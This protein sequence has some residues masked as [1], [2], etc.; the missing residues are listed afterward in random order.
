MKKLLLQLCIFPVLGFMLLTEPVFI[1]D[2]K[3]VFGQWKGSLTYLDYSSG[4]PYSMPANVTISKDKKNDHR[5]ILA[6]QYPDEPKANENDTLVIS[7][8]G[9]Q[10]DGAK[11]V[12]KEKTSIGLLQI[13]TEKQGVD[14]NDNRKA[15][16]KHI[17]TISKK[18][19]SIRK[20][21]RFDGEEKFI[22]RNEYKMNR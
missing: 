15:V 3:P 9:L 18:V 6:L 14:G 16:V 2:F 11:I 22:M 21:V 4:K 20:E 10:I 12:S 1:K 17:Y 13:I 19:L 5:L 8:D 7:N